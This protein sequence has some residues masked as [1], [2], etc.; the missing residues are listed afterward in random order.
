MDHLRCLRTVV[1][2]SGDVVLVTCAWCPSVI[3]LMIAIW[4]MSANGRGAPLTGSGAAIP[5]TRRKL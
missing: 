4:Q 2:C 3:V 5:G 1:E